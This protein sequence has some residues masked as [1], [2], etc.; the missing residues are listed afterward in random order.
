MNEEQYKEVSDRLATLEQQIAIQSERKSVVAS[1]AAESLIQRVAAATDISPKD[2]QRVLHELGL[3]GLERNLTGEN[4]PQT[5]VD[6]GRL[7]LAL[8]SNR[9]IL[10]A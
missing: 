9:Q 2:V 6:N 7:V 5:T 4:L 1:R 3:P 10:M 8:I